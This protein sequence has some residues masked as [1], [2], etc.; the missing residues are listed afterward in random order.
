M[1]VALLMLRFVTSI[2]KNTFSLECTP[3]SSKFCLLWLP[4]IFPPNICSRSVLTGWSTRLFGPIQWWQQVRP[5]LASSTHKFGL[6]SSA[7]ALIYVS[8]ICQC[9]IRRPFSPDFSPCVCGYDRS[10]Q[11]ILWRRRS[12]TPFPSSLYSH[13]RMP[14]GHVK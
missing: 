7:S 6:F 8:L 12:A 3:S 9:R 13:F 1:R 2:P 11:R 10:L 4:V 14:S 5:L